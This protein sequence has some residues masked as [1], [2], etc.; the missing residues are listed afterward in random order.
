MPVISVVIPLYN[1]EPIIERTI[2]SVLSQSSFNDFEVIVVDDGSTDG[3]A[4]V[5]E[6]FN[7]E[8]IRLICQKN[9]GPSKARNTGVEHARGEWIIFLD[10]DDELLPDALQT[11]YTLATDHHDADIIDCGQLLKT[12]GPGS[13][14][15]LFKRTLLLDYPYN[16]KLRRFEDA[17]LLV[18]MLESARVF[19]SDT[20]TSLVNCDYSSAS[21]VRKDISEDYI[22]HL[23]MKGKGF[24]A[25]MCIYRLYLENRM[26]YQEEMHR[27]YPTWR[28][29]YDWL[30]TYKLLN[31]FG[32]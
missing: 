4:A 3:S 30:L 10:A 19:S 22:G 31:K 8:R 6:R 13:N 23:S 28:Y 12:I 16:P 7:D 21:G 11:Y 5:V 20:I 27:Q 15:S 32:R 2:N 25:K 24:W 26:L 9:G 18:R 17:D 14:H 1:K 29:R